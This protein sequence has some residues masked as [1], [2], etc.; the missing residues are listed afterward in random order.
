MNAFD[1]DSED[2]KNFDAEGFGCN[3]TGMTQEILIKNAQVWISADREIVRDGSVL[4]RDGRIARA[5]RFHAR[6]DTVIDADGSLVMPGFVQGHVHLCQTIFRGGAEDMPL[7][8]WLTKYIWSLE[9]AH[10]ED[11]LRASAL[12]ACAELIKGGTTSFLSMETVHHTGVAFQTVSDVGLM[13]VI[14]HCLM[15]ESGGYKPLAVDTDDALADCD[16]LLDRWRDHDALRL[17][18]APRFALSCTGDNMRAAAA[19]ARDRGVLLHTHASEQVTEVELVRERTGMYNVEYLHS[20]GLTGKDVCLA[21]CVHTQPEERRILAET[22][23]RVLHCPSANLKLGS[24]IAPIPEY[25]RSG[26]TVAIGADGAPCNNRLDMFME[27]REAALLQK[28]R[29]GPHALPARDI[30]RM[31]TEGGATALMWS[32]EIGTLEEGKRANLIL[33]AQDS[34]HVL[35]SEDPAGNLVYANDAN[36]VVMTIVNGRILYEDG[37]LTTIDEDKL[38]EQVRKQRKKLFERAGLG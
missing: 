37:K 28:I 16:L 29:L 1:G 3:V 14:S 35:P 15:D 32:D 18:V 23:T 17:A 36:D 12:L 13:G 2:H 38:K 6:A 4:I 5:G 8:P 34:V 20:I 25:L 22:D 10:D 19:Y 21:H 26:M 33:V 27:M 9:A 30:V 7:L 31:A 24:G 11:S